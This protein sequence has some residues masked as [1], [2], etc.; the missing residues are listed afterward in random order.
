MHHGTIV[1]LAFRRPKI[2]STLVTRRCP[3]PFRSF[4]F[5]LLQRSSSECNVNARRRPVHFFLNPI[6]LPF[7]LS[8]LLG[9]PLSSVVCF[10]LHTLLRLC[11]FLPEG[12]LFPLSFTILRIG[13]TRWLC[14]LFVKHSLKNDYVCVVNEMF[15]CRLVREPENNNRLSSS[16]LIKKIERIIIDRI[17]GTHYSMNASTTTIR[18]AIVHA[19]AI[20]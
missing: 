17:I 15:N 12:S 20:R 10:L 7:Y 1:L 13:E 8:Y 9:I 6:L 4:L 3:F 14:H 11:S 2:G 19:N 18:V 5:I 16:T